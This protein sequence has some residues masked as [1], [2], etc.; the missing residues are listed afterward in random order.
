MK[1]IQR[2]HEGQSVGFGGFGGDGAAHAQVAHLIR[3]VILPGGIQILRIPLGKLHKGHGTDEGLAGIKDIHPRVAV[4]I[5]PQP[6]MH[7]HPAGNPP[8][9]PRRKVD[10]VPGGSLIFP[11]P[12]L[13][14]LQQ[15][16][17]EFAAPHIIDYIE[18]FRKGSCKELFFV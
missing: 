11:A 6:V 18:I 15:L 17:K 16:Q 5:E 8:V 4:F 9:I 2:V 7:L 1:L 10:P 14:R 3:A 13:A 12:N